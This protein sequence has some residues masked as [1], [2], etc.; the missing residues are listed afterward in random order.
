MKGAMSVSTPEQ[1]EAIPSQF[2]GI[3]DIR[4]ENLVEVI[5]RYFDDNQTRLAESM[6]VQASVIS[7]WVKGNRTVGNTSARRVE[8]AAGKPKYWL[9]MKHAARKEI[10]V[11]DCKLSGDKRRFH[12]TPAGMAA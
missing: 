3:S 1:A 6:S 12:P 4:R 7:R 2:Y 9:D 11:S 8:Q 5:R 10:K